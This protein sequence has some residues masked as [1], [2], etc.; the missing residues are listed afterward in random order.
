MSY[1]SN[2][3]ANLAS[4]KQGHN[5]TPR[6]TISSSPSKKILPKQYLAHSKEKDNQQKRSFVEP[7]QIVDTED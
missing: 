6:L 1:I 2:A 4:M 7:K 5:L 3:S